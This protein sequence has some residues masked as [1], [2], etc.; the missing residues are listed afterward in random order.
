M[1]KHNPKNGEVFITWEDE[2]FVGNIQDIEIRAGVSQLTTFT[3]S[4]IVGNVR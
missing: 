1:L 4:G 2:T 3:I